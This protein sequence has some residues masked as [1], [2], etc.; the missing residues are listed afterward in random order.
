LKVS[1]PSDNNREH[2]RQAAMRRG[3][4]VQ[5]PSGAAF[6][7]VIIDVSLGGA[8]LQLIGADIPDEGLTLI[9][10]QMGASHALRV[11]W[12]KDP[13]VGVAFTESEILP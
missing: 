2:P 3:V 5:Q 12:R 6:V 4:V 8:R 10:A 11:V 9:D 1:A 7:C 13:F